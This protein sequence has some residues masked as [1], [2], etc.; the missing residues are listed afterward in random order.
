MAVNFVNINDTESA[1]TLYV[2]IN[3]EEITLGSD[4]SEIIT[5]LLHSFLSNY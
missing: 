1:G 5:K 3:N 2:R 4:T